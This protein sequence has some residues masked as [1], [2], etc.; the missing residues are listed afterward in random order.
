MTRRVRLALWAAVAFAATPALADVVRANSTTL[1]YTRED[2][3]AG[4]LERAAPVF[5]LVSITATEVSAGFAE[6]VEIAL[7]T[8]GALDLADERRWQNGPMTS[9]RVS[10][11]VDVGY[12]KG[13]LLGR[14]MVLRLGRFLVPEGNARMVHL[15]GAETRFR[16][17]FGFGLSAYVGSPVASRFGARGGELTIGNERANVSTG[18]RVSWFYPR[19]LEAGASI[20]YARDRGD[21][22][23]QD[24]GADLRLFL[25]ADIQVVGAGF[26]SLI[27][28]RLGE[29][30]VSASWRASREL[31]LTGN[32]RHVEP[33][34]FLPRTSILSVF[35]ED[36]RDEVGGAVRIEPARG[37][38]FDANY[39]TLFESA[40]TGHRARVK[41]VWHPRST[42]DLGG[43][44]VYL[45]GPDDGGY[46]LARAFAAWRR[47]AL[48]LT[49]D[50][51]TVF[52]ERRVNDEKFDLSGTVTAGYRFAP[53]WK[54]LVAGT[55]GTSPFLSSHFDV[56]AKLVYDQTYVTREVP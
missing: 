42:S 37:L 47:T 35:A 46:W 20:A 40:G 14:R 30:D 28:E 49:G 19:L 8:W 44:T 3:Y 34:L 2:P 41:G 16:L 11:D 17:P 13:E 27:E 51:M 39:H 9:R 5:Q 29:A 23:R 33:D 6:E 48:E 52:L 22:A 53:R 32:Y 55:A 45:T 56:L 10:G 38:T 24:A 43:E 36:Q 25:P 18:G 54:A 4:D 15:D 31:Q 1:F 21:I 26:Y 50:L 7:S 12:I